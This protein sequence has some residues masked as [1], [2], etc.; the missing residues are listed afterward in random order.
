MNIFL[1]TNYC[2]DCYCYSI[3]ITLIGNNKNVDNMPDWF[4]NDG[5][6]SEKS[7]IENIQSVVYIYQRYSH[8]ILLD[9]AEF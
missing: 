3:E 7:P 2:L 6:V 9:G 4:F 1:L 8:L 5:M